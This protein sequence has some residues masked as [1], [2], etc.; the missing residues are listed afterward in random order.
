MAEDRKW[1]NI[2]KKSTEQSTGEKPLVDNS[3]EEEIPEWKSSIR[4][5]PLTE[6]AEPEH[7]LMK[8]KKTI[9]AAA[10]VIV[11]GAVAFGVTPMLINRGTEAKKQTEKDSA[12]TKTESPSEKES[13]EP[14]SPQ[15]MTVKKAQK[16]Q[17]QRRRRYLR[18]PVL[19]ILR[20]MNLCMIFCINGRVR[21]QTGLLLM[22]HGSYPQMAILWN[23]MQRQSVT[24]QQVQQHLMRLPKIP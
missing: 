11:V 19:H 20:V 6:K 23:M 13:E 21:I 18:L 7:K 2:R 5:E 14:A 16:I 8:H 12:D 10:A 9:A 1:K 17:R 22:V 3:H 4:K 24:V 15:N